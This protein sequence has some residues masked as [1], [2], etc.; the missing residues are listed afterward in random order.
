ML[1][2]KKEDCEILFLVII[3]PYSIKNVKNMYNQSLLSAM[4]VLSIFRS[5]VL[6]SSS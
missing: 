2:L 3:Y 5:I 1:Y 4:V 6:N